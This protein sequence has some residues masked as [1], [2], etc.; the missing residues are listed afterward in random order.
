MLTSE[1]AVAEAFDVAEEIAAASR[2]SWI[3]LGTILH[4]PLAGGEFLEIVQATASCWEARGCFAGDF[5]IIGTA[6][7]R[8]D[9]LAMADAWLCSH[10]SLRKL[11]LR[12]EI[13]RTRTATDKQILRAVELTGLSA[14]F[15]SNLSSGQISDLIRSAYALAL[16]P[17]ELVFARSSLSAAQ[18]SR[19]N[20]PHSWQV[21]G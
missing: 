4:M 10:A 9:A 6:L 2:Y 1:Q 15:L 7:N 17:E 20:K 21:V 18:V 8:A 14:T 13:W 12:D 11:I 16:S 5:H 3:P 19:S